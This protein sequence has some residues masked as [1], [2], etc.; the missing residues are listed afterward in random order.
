[1]VDL[2][3]VAKVRRLLA[4]GTRS[5][6]SIAKLTGMSRGTVGAIAAGKWRDPRNSPRLSKN[7]CPELSETPSW[8]PGCGALVYMPCLLCLARSLRQKNSRGGT[9]RGRPPRGTVGIESP[10]RPF[11][12]L[13]GSP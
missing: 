9:A 4:A 8:C 10:A 12:S 3:T 6:R 13:S 2:K 5:Q 1:M 11:R 7:E